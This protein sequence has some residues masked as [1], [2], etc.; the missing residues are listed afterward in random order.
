MD[1]PAVIIGLGANNIAIPLIFS[2]S[3]KNARK[4][5]ES[6]GFVLDDKNSCA[7][8]YN[9]SFERDEE[10]RFIGNSLKMIKGLFKNERYRSGCGGCYVL[11]IKEIDFNTPIVEWDLD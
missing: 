4:Y 2:S 3:I 1:K 5:L 7:I 10:Y 8:P 11:V 9:G 6:L